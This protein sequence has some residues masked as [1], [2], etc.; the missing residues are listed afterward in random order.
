MK[1]L[2]KCKQDETILAEKKISSPKLPPHSPAPAISTLPSSITPSP[3]LPTSVKTPV[4]DLKPS[5]SAAS[6]VPA[7]PAVTNADPR[8]KSE[9]TQEHILKEIQTTL[10]ERKKLIN[11]VSKYEKGI[12]EMFDSGSSPLHNVCDFNFI[13]SACHLST[14]SFTRLHLFSGW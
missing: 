6:I 7:P 13:F 1:L 10:E 4:G 9:I 8:P 2:E 11:S 14:A 12:H 3:M 5:V